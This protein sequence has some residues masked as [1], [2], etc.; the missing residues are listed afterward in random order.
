MKKEAKSKNAKGLIQKAS[1]EKETTSKNA[2]GLVQ[3][4]SD[5]K[6]GNLEKRK[7]SHP[8]DLR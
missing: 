1:D 7:E 8:K 5:E 4:T 3:N 2:K 6:R